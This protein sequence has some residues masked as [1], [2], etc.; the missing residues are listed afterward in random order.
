MAASGPECAADDRARGK[1]RDAVALDR[2][3]G[4]PQSRAA[5]AYE[6]P[7]SARVHPQATATVGKVATA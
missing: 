7:R 5:Q 4:D 2:G 3:R 1:S 6:Q